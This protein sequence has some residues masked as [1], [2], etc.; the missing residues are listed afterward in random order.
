MTYFLAS[1]ELR[2]GATVT[3]DGAEAAHILSARRLRPG[4]TFE[5][6]DPA[7]RRFVMELCPGPARKVTARV[8][9]PALLPP[10]PP[11]ALTLLQAAVK[12]KAAETILRQA[13]ELGVARL[14]VF[15]SARAPG[16]PGTGGHAS[17]AAKAHERWLRIAWEACKQC[18]RPA[19]PDLLLLDS[20]QRALDAARDDADNATPGWFLHPAAALTP[21]AALTSHR[22]GPPAHARLAVGPEGGFAPDEVAALEAAGFAAVALPGPILRADT[23]ALTGC[24]LML[25]GR[26]GA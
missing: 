18:G 23:A 17:A 16:R 5:L 21:Q 4:E 10:P 11:L 20:L 3:L 7:G 22:G 25:H 9:R 19:P 24:S 6:Q 2:D 8:L 26:W 14:F 13:T 15:P 12:D 1:D